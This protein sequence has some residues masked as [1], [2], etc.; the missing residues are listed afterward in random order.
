MDWL[1]ERASFWVDLGLSLV[2]LLTLWLVALGLLLFRKPRPTA[3]PS[4]EGAH[5]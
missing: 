3:Q 2:S 5:G 1:H 4:G